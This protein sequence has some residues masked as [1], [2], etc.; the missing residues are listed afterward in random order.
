M[1]MSSQ[2]TIPSMD[3]DLYPFFSPQEK[4]DRTKWETFKI[5]AKYYIPLF[6]WI[7]NYS[8]ANFLPDL[9]SGL[10]VAALIVPQS[11]SYATSLVKVDPVYGLYAATF[12][13]LI[14][15]V[16]GTSRQLSVGPS[17]VSALLTG[18]LM[19]SLSKNIEGGSVDPIQVMILTSFF[20]GLVLFGLG[21]AR[22]GFLD[23]LMSHVL[24]VGLVNGL[25]CAIMLVQIP[26]QLGISGDNDH[27][28]SLDNLI[29][30]FK[31]ITNIHLPSALISFLSVSFLL[32]FKFAC[33]KFPE[34]KWLKLVPS[35][36]ILVVITTFFSWLLD[37]RQYD[38]PILEKIEGTYIWPKFPKF[39][40][41]DYTSMLTTATIIA[42]I[43]YVES[44]AGAKKFAAIHGTTISPNRE[45]VALGT[46]NIICSFFSCFP[47]SCSLSRSEI[48]NAGG[49][50]SQVASVVTSA[51][52]ILIVKFGLVLFYHLP[53]PVM[54]SIVFF[55][56][57]K[58]I[59]LSEFTFL[60]SLK[61]WM[62]ICRLLLVFLVTVFVSI[63]AGTILLILTSILLVLK[64]TAKPRITILG[65][66]GE[67]FRPVCEYPNALQFQHIMIL[68]IDEDLYFA[69]SGQL[70]DRMKRV[71][72]HR[73]FSTHPSEDKGETT[74]THVIFE[75]SLVHR[76]D[77][78]AVRVFAEII[79][80]FHDRGIQVSIVRMNDRLVSVFEKSGLYELI[81]FSN[82]HRRVSDALE[83]ADIKELNRND[84][85]ESTEV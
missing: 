35:T 17:A 75:L 8:K 32:G 64:K 19:A 14:Y 25:G 15:T 73:D 5:R 24:L 55:A 67:K 26:I 80:D 13:L 27:P 69:N 61:A 10:S 22:F 40:K 9:L 29:L 57:S 54:S 30:I 42:V 59:N 68:K 65:R 84:T 76:L 47:T 33:K 6:G 72:H 48:N 34:K 74:I 46:V 23:S 3:N 11:M 70:K 71:E 60:F 58:L 38:V 44:I 36:F 2:D 45:M 83:S 12:P 16:L 66:V 82:F 7:S 37:I 41:I 1:P 52:V 49:A 4:I 18:N 43:G 21:L 56:A 77:S 51:F 85:L 20:A 50:K 28:S 79:S 81:G 63:E 62:D 39:L 31:N 53:V 78:F